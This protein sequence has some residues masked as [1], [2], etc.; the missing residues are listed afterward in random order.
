MVQRVIRSLAKACWEVLGGTHLTNNKLP[1]SNLLKLIMSL[2]KQPSFIQTYQF[3]PLLLLR[4]LLPLL[5]DVRLE[6]RHHG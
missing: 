6:F 1:R 4:L 2:P 5:V 3:S